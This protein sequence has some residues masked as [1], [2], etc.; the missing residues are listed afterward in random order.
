MG[1]TATWAG[2][3]T[4]IMG[5]LAFVSA[6]IVGKATERFDPRAILSIGILAVIL[7][8]SMFLQFR[9]NP[10]ATDPVQQ[11]VF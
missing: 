8:I 1:Y 5:L 6:P 2:Y 9:L 11:Q 3:A 4:G 7:G 10:Q